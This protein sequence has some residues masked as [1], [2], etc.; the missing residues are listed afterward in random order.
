MPLA[1]HSASRIL[2][3]TAVDVTS[4][5]SL[6][7]MLGL[8]LEHW[9][10]PTALRR[11]AP[12]SFAKHGPRGVCE[13][14]VT[15]HC[16]AAFICSPASCSTTLSGASLPSIHAPRRCCAVNLPPLNVSAILGTTRNCHLSSCCWVPSPHQDAPKNN[17]SNSRPHTTARGSTSSDSLHGCRVH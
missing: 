6:S 14:H 17:N 12:S 15:V 10:E 3:P 2:V 7:E 9:T 8:L 11:A 13:P 1:F 16:S 4:M 5:A